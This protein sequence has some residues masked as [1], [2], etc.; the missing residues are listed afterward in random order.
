MAGEE[1]KADAPSIIENME[2]AVGDQLKSLG[3][4]LDGGMDIAS[5][6][7]KSSTALVKC[8]AENVTGLAKV[9]KH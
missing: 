2:N 7:L 6:A 5:D 1:P 4:V 8:E 3:A 9:C